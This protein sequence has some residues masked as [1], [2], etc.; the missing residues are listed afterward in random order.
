MRI[1]PATIQDA[2]NMARVKVD[3]WRSTY[4][5]IVPS[6]YLESL[7]CEQITERWRQGI[8][9]SRNPDLA[10][11]VAEEAGGQVVGI[12]RCGPLEGPQRAGVG[13]VYVLYVLPEFQRRGVGRGLM[14]ACGRHLVGRGMNSLVVWV[15]KDNPYRSFYEGLGG[16]LTGEKQ[17]EIGGTTLLEVA[18]EWADIRQGLDLTGLEDL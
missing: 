12:A 15:L 11:Y 4:S 13:Q 3:T 9:Q 6:A 2:G 14:Q 5:G 8:L 16:V 10:A 18:Y 1:R 7:S 17:T